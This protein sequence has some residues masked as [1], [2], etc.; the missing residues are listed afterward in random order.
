MLLCIFLAR[1]EG[2]QVTASGEG[3]LSWVRRAD[4]PRLDL[5]PD[6]HQVLPELLDPGKAGVWFGHFRYDAS[7]ALDAVAG[8]WSPAGGWWDCLCR[9]TGD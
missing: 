9:G 2:R 6:L 5:V 4:L 7:G 1:A 8:Q 3:S